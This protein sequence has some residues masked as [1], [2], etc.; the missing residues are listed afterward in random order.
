MGQGLIFFLTVLAALRA[1][2]I[3]PLKCV[4]NH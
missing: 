2:I 3:I 4:D 1:A